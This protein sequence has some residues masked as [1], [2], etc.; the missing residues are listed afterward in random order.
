MIQW[1]EKMYMNGT[2]SLD[3]SPDKIEIANKFIK[4]ASIN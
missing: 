3:C 1:F 2:Y 4:I